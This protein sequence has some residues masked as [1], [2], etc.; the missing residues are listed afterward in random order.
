MQSIKLILIIILVGIKEIFRWIWNKIKSFFKW[1]FSKT[2]IDEK[3][4]EVAEEIADRAKV[5]NE[6]IKDVKEALKEVANQ[7]KDVAKAAKG[8]KR[9]GR[10]KKRM[11]LAPTEEEGKTIVV[12][13]NKD[14]ISDI[15]F[16][17]G[18][19]MDDAKETEEK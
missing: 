19:S 7:S 6:E 3:V 4:I 5:V 14:S 1:I 16:N 12:K 9:R 8:Q 18:F 15:D 13:D 11:K 17:Q 10:P 2:T